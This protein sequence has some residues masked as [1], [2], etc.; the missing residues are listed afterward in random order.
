[1][2]GDG[3]LERL[4]APAGERDAPAVAQ[5][6]AGDLAPDPGSGPGDDGDWRLLGHGAPRSVA[7]RVGPQAC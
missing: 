3:R 4:G 2:A 1:V 7:V 6:R 5:Q